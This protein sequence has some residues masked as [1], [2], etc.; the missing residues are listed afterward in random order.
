MK[1]ELLDA[2]NGPRFD[3]QLASLGGV[4]RI[5]HSDG[6]DANEILTATSITNFNSEILVVQRLIKV[7]SGSVTHNWR[8]NFSRLV[9]SRLESDNS[10]HNLMTFSPADF[11]NVESLEDPRFGLNNSM[12]EIW[13]AAC[14]F[15][16]PET[17]IRQL[18]IKLKPDFSVAN[19]FYPLFGRNA[20]V[21]YEKN[22]CP[23]P[24]TDLFVYE[25][26]GGFTVINRVTSTSW[27]SQ[28]LIWPF[29]EIHCGSSPILVEG[30]YLMFFHSSL[31]LNFELSE[32]GFSP[33]HY[34]VGA[35]IF[36]SVPPYRILAS[37]KEPLFA[38]SFRNKTVNGSP[39]AVF[40]T[41]STLLN[42][43]TLLFSLQLNDC[44]SIVAE[45]PIEALLRK[46]AYF[47]Q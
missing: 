37:T 25:C 13:L 17:S 7:N 19:S 28:G 4:S 29:G 23:I 11:E 32:I 47:S 39:A 14:K 18:V 35:L 5:L 41:G 42:A 21:G 12:L 16:R 24:N 3:E 36:S 27:S 20:E 40:V 10:V 45:V 9:L 31:N 2:F 43:S 34:F 26:G 1:P 46:L 30:N 33:R 6:L 44:E 22:W 15:S 8:R 38:G